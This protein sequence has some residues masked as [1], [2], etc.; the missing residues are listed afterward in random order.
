M[1]Q[2][3]KFFLFPFQEFFQYYSENSGSRPA[4]DEENKIDL[5]KKGVVCCK[6]LLDR[7]S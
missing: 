3:N 6:L 5:L 2:L 1:K 4:S 7:F